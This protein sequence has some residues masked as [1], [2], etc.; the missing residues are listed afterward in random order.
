MQKPEDRTTE[1]TPYLLLDPASSSI[2]QRYFF[3]Q[4]VSGGF[5]DTTTRQEETMM[6]HS[7]E[8]VK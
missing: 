8:C 6:N 5:G 1:S 3:R 7:F 2:Q 4:G